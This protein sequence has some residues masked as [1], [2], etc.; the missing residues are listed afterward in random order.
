MI[1]FIGIGKGGNKR[2]IFPS[3]IKSKSMVIIVC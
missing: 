1:R 2:D 3:L